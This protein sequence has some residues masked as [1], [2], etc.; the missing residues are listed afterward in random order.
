[1]WSRTSLP[2]KLKPVVVAVAVA[3]KMH[4][5]SEDEIAANATNNYV[6]PAASPT[7]Q[8][9]AAIDSIPTDSSHSS[10]ATPTTSLDCCCRAYDSQLERRLAE[11][12]RLV[13]E[14]LEELHRRAAE[15]TRRREADERKTAEK[16]RHREATCQH[17]LLPLLRPLVYAYALVIVMW[18]W[19]HHLR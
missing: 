9:A 13:T 7:A 1:M 17:F 4:M 15:D 18:G 19:P 6:S 10:D 8:P 16:N 3:T 2:L 12:E 14:L 5:R 11:A